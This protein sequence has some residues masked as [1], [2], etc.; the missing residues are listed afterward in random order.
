MDLLT[1]ILAAGAGLTSIAVL[2]RVL[3]AVRHKLWAGV[4]ATPKAVASVVAPALQAAT[5]RRF[6]DHIED[7]GERLLSLED[8]QEQ[9]FL[10]LVALDKRKE[11]L[12]RA[13]AAARRQASDNALK[14]AYVDNRSPSP[15]S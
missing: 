1:M 12:D 5:P 15:K 11:R 10:N 6:N 8:A 7:I 13:L 4:K 2:W 14:G 9:E 3:S